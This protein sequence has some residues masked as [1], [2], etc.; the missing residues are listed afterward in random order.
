[1]NSELR[2]TEP[3]AGSVGKFGLRGK[4]KLQFRNIRISQV[5]KR[6]IFYRYVGDIKDFMSQNFRRLNV[7]IAILHIM[8]V[9]GYTRFCD[10]TTSLFRDWF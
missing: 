1:M 3:V 8:P 10:Y 5:V 7:D 6:S 9:Y 2:I 4:L